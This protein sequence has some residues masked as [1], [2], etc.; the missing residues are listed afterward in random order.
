LKAEENPRLRDQS[1]RQIDF[2]QFFPPPPDIRPET[3]PHVDP[4]IAESHSAK[5]RF[6][7]LLR[8]VRVGGSDWANLIFVLVAIVGGLFLSIRYFRSSESFRATAKWPRE[9]LY[10]RPAGTESYST[11][12]NTTSLKQSD[13]PAP[14][15]VRV[16][17]P[18]DNFTGRNPFAQVDHPL[19]PP[20]PVATNNALPFV[21]ATTSNPTSAASQQ[22]VARAASLSPQ[23][24]KGGATAGRPGPSSPTSARPADQDTK[25]PVEPSRKNIH[26]KQDL[27]PGKEICVKPG[28]RQIT[29]AQKLVRI[30]DVRRL[31]EN[32]AAR[33]IRNFNGPGG[34][35]A[36]TFNSN[37]NSSRAGSFGAPGSGFGGRH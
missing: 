15:P 23:A 36:R 27:R 31:Q 28:N 17:P 5:K 29:D 22:S 34:G 18:K 19:G 33:A 24:S 9:F 6:S 37:L 8:H 2:R 10:Q 13:T 12:I 14:E 16:L 35:A 3:H 11:T 30:E 32:L 7:K 21:P 1:E 25:T 20:P 26:G 4:N